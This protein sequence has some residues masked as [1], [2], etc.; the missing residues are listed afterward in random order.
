MMKQKIILVYS[1]EIEPRHTFLLW[2]KNHENRIINCYHRGDI[3][4]N[5]KQRPL[6]NQKTKTKA[7]LSR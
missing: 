4:Q 7:S 5:P 1:P 6:S 2:R 3:K